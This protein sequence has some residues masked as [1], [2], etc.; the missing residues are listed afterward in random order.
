MRVCR[1]ACCWDSTPQWRRRSER[2]IVTS[3]IDAKPQYL[4]RLPGPSW[5]PVLAGVGTAVFFLALT[6]KWII[7]A[8]VGVI[9][10]IV[11]I[12]KWLWESDPEP[13]GKLYDIGGGIRLPDYVS[14][15]ESHSWWSIVVL[16]L[17]DGSIYA[18]AVFSFYYLWTI[19]P[20]GFPPAGLDLPLAG[21]SFASALCWAASAAAMWFA[22]RMLANKQSRAFDAALAGAFVLMLVAAVLNVYALTG[23][24]VSPQAHGYAATS[25]MIVTWQGVH[26]V[27]LTFMV[28]FT[29]AR[30]LTGKLDSIRRNTFDNTQIMW[31]FSA[32]QALIGLLV[33]HTPRFVS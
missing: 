26:A 10:A 29:L 32:A 33:I 9:V 4:L 22:N 5:W 14:G 6:V 23:T 2:A 15:S 12:L 11:S 16:M 30:H 3:A 17:V 28:L 7:P 21:V 20:T 31:Y 1:W 19:L 13:T 25:Y 27:L 8:L 24:N 18:C